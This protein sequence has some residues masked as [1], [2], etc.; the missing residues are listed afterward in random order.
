M[1]IPKRCFSGVV[2]AG[3]NQPY[4][5]MSHKGTPF[6]PVRIV[7]GPLTVAALCGCKFSKTKPF[8]DGSHLLWPVVN[9]KS[10]ESPSELANA[11]KKRVEKLRES[12]EIE[13]LDDLEDRDV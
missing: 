3:K 10:R 6:K 9:R 7:P 13:L 4:C 1:W 8:C 11:L 12:G 2:V 5:D